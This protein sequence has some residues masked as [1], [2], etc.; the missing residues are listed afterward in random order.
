M[1][2]NQNYKYKC[3]DNYNPYIIYIFATI[4]YYLSL[5]KFMT[6]IRLYRLLAYCMKFEIALQFY[7]E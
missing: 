3:L 5:C 2:G 1:I 4:I 7:Q 6:S